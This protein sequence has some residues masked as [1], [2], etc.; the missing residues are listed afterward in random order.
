M[1]NRRNR[2]RLAGAAAV[3]AALL[4]AFLPGCGKG[5]INGLLP[6]NQ[7]PEVELTQVP[8]STTQQYFYAY[9]IRWAGFDADGSIDHYL[10]CID[11]PT[12]ALAD[13]PWVSTTENRGTFVFRANNVDSA[14]AGTGHAFHTFVVKAVDNGGLASAPAFSSFNSY[15]ITPT[16]RITA[17]VANHLFTPTFGPSFRIEWEGNDPDGRS[18]H[19]PVK[20]K[21]KILHDG[22]DF[23]MQIAL[24]RPDS[25][26]KRYAPSF[27]EWDSVGG[28]TTKLD[29]RELLE[30]AQ[31]VVIVA[32]DEA[33]AYSPVFQLDLNMF[34]C[35]VTYS[36]QLGPTLTLYNEYLYYK[37]AGP[38]FSLDPTTFLQAE[39]PADVP[40]PFHWSGAAHSGTFVSGYRWRVDGDLGDETPR[41]DEATDVGHWSRWSQLTTDCTIPAISPPPGEYSQTHFFYLEARDAEN[42]TSLAVVQFDVLRPRHD[43]DL[44]IV[45]DTRF[46]LDTRASTG[47]LD[48]PTGAWPTA[49]ELDTFLYAV[50]NVPWR[51]YA[52]A[53]QSPPGLFAGY[54]YD[55][56]GTRYQPGGLLTLDYL[57]RYR[58]L[59]W[60]VDYK[61]AQLT[62]PVDYVRDPMPMLH[63][64]SYPGRTNPL[65]AWVKQ[66]G[67][68]WIQGGG[69]AQCMQEPWEKY[70]TNALV[71]AN[72]DT[73]LVAGRFMFDIAHWRSEIT[74]GL[75]R[76]AGR[77][78]AGQ[79]PWAGMPDYAKLPSPLTEKTT[80]SDPFATYAP[81]RTRAGDFYQTVFQ[82][83]VLTKPNTVAEDA[84]PLPN[85]EDLEPTLDT[86]YATTA[87][88]LGP[89]KPIMTLYHGSENAPLVFSG[90]PL[91]YFQ[92]GQAAGVIDFVLQDLWGMTKRT[93]ATRPAYSAAPFAPAA[94]PP[95]RTRTTRRTAAPPG[96]T[97][98]AK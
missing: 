54:D 53:V 24:L 37:Y 49:A 76:Q 27:S 5:K 18:S 81:R 59:I 58:K 16:V 15:T 29:L 26:R 95:Q 4:L 31:M 32:F 47:Y 94:A 84:D 65:T 48:I 57:G 7:R 39:F 73:E 63:H 96:V 50:G 67:L 82:G 87:G 92:R 36:G 38:Q 60:L 44:L 56:I 97:S 10:Y 88:A 90:F 1:T 41:S 13:T 80:A 52:D 40:I 68:A 77:S 3:A 14:T 79:H 55:T 86:L 61:S 33:G 70:G 22:G 11:P 19:K 8:A 25:L 89:N 64:V 9:E 83:E 74:E 66:G 42:Q 71:H 75:G 93:S 6:A 51:G 28:D 62:N 12:E 69:A 2:R 23:D 17:P 21:Y 43:R 78:T 35:N 34:L 98:R 91:W 20:Y 30:G 85:V 45:D 72:A 46:K